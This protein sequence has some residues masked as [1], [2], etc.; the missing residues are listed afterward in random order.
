M[1]ISYKKF[2]R[3]TIILILQNLL[4]ISLIIIRITLSQSLF[5][6]FLIWNLVLAAIPWLISNFVVNKPELWTKKWLMILLGTIWLLFFPNSPYILT[7]LFH[8]GKSSTMPLW[9]DLMVILTAAW[10]GLIF[11]FTSIRH[12]EQIL[13]SF[14]SQRLK[15]IA[16]IAVFFISSFGIYL[17]RF[18]RWNSWD[19][20]GQP[21]R[22]MNDVSDIVL[23]PGHNM[24]TWWMTLVFG[25]FLCL[26]YWSITAFKS[27]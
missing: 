12:L 23:N 14:L 7:D 6:A 20:I 27:A 13:N 17:G 25:L 5:Y 24:D 26:S 11:G 2:N 22:I 8:L 19:I 10:T 3:I 21:L 16:I 9:F 4:C 15:T 1:I 18:L